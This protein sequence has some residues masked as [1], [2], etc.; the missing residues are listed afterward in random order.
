MPFENPLLATQSG[1][2]PSETEKYVAPATAAEDPTEE[3]VFNYVTYRER[4]NDYNPFRNSSQQF[5][6]ANKDETVYAQATEAELKKQ[7]EDSPQTK[8]TFGDFENY[9][10]YI[11]EAQDLVLKDVDWMAS[12]R[13]EY[14]P[15]SAAGARDRGEDRGWAPG[16]TKALDEQKYQDE[17]GAV[18]SGYQQWLSTE[19][20]KALLEKYGIQPTIIT[21]E[22]DYRV[23]TGAGYAK[24]QTEPRSMDTGDYIKAAAAVAGA[25]AT[26]GAASGALGGGVLGGAAGAGLGSVVGQAVTTGGV[27]LGQVGRS[28]LTGGISGGLDIGGYMPGEAG[29]LLND[30]T[31]GAV[32][33]GVTAA[34]EGGSIKD[35]IISG[36]AGA[37]LTNAL[38]NVIWDVSG[39]TGLDHG[40]VTDVIKGAVDGTINGDDVE[41]ILMQAAGTAGADLAKGWFTQTVGQNGLDVDNWFKEGTTNISNEAVNSL[42]DTISG[43]VVDGEFDVG[44]LA[45]GALD[46]AQAGGSFAFADPDINLPDFGG[47][48]DFGGLPDVDFSKGD[49]GVTQDEE[50]NYTVSG[51]VDWLPDGG[52]NFPAGTD[53]GYIEDA[54]REAGRKFDDN[55]VQPVLEAGREFDD[56]VL[57]PVK[58]ALPQGTTPDLNVENPLPEIDIDLPPIDLP[59]IDLPVGSDGGGMLGGSNDF[60]WKELFGYTQLPNYQKQKRKII[61]FGNRGGMLS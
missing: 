20:N 40:T 45:K 2:L 9:M 36:A 12:Q 59:S 7:F 57:Q 48:I 25:V 51:N 46:Y 58:D 28:V 32:V 5:G 49:W 23:W 6:Y 35:G 4:G 56:T 15:G 22:G 27:D 31:T 3:E 16:Q 54:I 33:G 50:G 61:D 13:A 42:V 14:R 41:D 43:A 60:D 19:E 18:K 21:P 1:E 38:D 44:D 29:S 53:L 26:G 55:V 10:N 8:E 24:Q 37:G 47:G 17:Q 39:A 11:R 34:A 52:L 30:V